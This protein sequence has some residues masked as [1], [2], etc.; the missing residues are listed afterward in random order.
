MWYRVDKCLVV[1]W[2]PGERERVATD[3]GRPSHGQLALGIGE[4]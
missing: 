4:P 1:M 2:A 3:G